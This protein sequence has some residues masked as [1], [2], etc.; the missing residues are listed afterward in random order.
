MSWE[1]LLP[2]CH[3]E[4]YGRSSGHPV[5]LLVCESITPADFG[6]RVAEVENRSRE[7]RFP[8]DVLLKDR[9]GGEDLVLVRTLAPQKCGYVWIVA[10]P[11]Q[12]R[13]A[14]AISGIHVGAVL[15]EEF[16]NV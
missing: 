1:Y 10:C 15:Y 5:H 2:S 6:S 11:G 7:R 16:D 12:R 14:L 13:F 4:G 9:L 3:R 8:L